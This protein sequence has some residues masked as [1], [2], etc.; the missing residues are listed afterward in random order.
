MK[1]QNLN[2]PGAGLVIWLTG[3]SGAGKTTLARTLSAQLKGAGLQVET[4]DGDEVRENLSR[5]LGFSQQDRDVNVRRIGFVARLLARNGVVVLGAAISP[6]RHSRDDVRR[7]I[8]SEGLRFLEV[9]VRCPLDALIKRDVKGLYARALAGEI[10]Q[11]TGISDPYEEPLAPEIV[12]DTSTDSIE[13]SAARILNAIWSHEEQPM[14][15]IEQI[16][17]QKDG[18]D[19][20]ADIHRYAAARDHLISTAD[21]ALFK[22]YGVYTQR[23]ASDGFFMV[24]IRIPGGQLT[25]RQLLT[26]AELSDAYGR[27]LADI[28]VRQNIQLHWVRIEDIPS[29]FEALT[30]V[31]LTTTEACGDTVRNIINCPVSGVDSD[32]LYDASALI[33][34]VNDFFVGNR[35]FSN[36]PRKF[37]I[38]ISGCALRCVYPEI[39]DIGLFAVRDDDGAVRFRARIGG[40]LST[41]PRFS[42]D[43]GVLIEPG[44][45][46][47]LCAAIAAVF[48]DE[49][50]RENRRRARLK[51][52]VEQWELPRFRDAVESRL[53]RKLRRAEQPEAAPVT[54][55]DRTHLGIHRQRGDSSH[56]CG[57]AIVG[58]RT[59]ADRLRILAELAEKHGRGRIRTT[60]TQNIILLDIESENV[61]SLKHELT[62]AGFDYDPSWA[63]RGLIACTGIQF[64]KLAI[65]ETK[66]RVRELEAYLTE[67]VDLEDRPR[68]SVT[69]CPN[70]CG[71]H[72]ICD[73]GLEGSLTTIDGVKQETFQVFLGGGVGAHE[74]FGRRI[75]VRIPSEELAESLARLFTAYKE[76]QLEGET[77]QEFCL[78]HS[79][80][81]LT[82]YLLAAPARPPKA[83]QHD[84]ARHWGAAD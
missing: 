70:A 66:N 65:A 63:R 69:G 84:V 72:H 80:E 19:A 46:V 38:A 16:K 55:R 9:F 8:E 76:E 45:V 15:K 75:G 12:V 26:I 21:E 20:V 48:R 36:L 56:Y 28:T 23:P 42:K 34:R 37:K 77:F 47:E 73:V 71:Q 51:F 53:R 17:Q 31:G 50:N 74:T 67:H 7:S 64:C 44:E 83:I 60:N 5:G 57:I 32:E 27:G 82:H 39:N 43:L 13:E 58:G 11:F 33:T 10:K 1:K 18:L 22:W 52:L 68:I 4:L 3:L 79:N 49:G 54:A 41:T 35:E 61:D 2:I 81:E 62:A 6:Y 30:R 29:I 25:S 24:R 78:R 40:G 59:S 14:N